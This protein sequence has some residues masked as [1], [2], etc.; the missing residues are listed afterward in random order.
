MTKKEEEKGATLKQA[1]KI[2][3][4]FHDT[5]AEQ[6]QA[7]LESGFLADLR[8][9]NL[10]EVNRW[11]FR[12]LIGLRPYDETMI[13]RLSVIAIPASCQSGTVSECIAKMKEGGQRIYTRKNFEEMFFDKAVG[14]IRKTRL[15]RCDL[16]VIGL[17]SLVI[18]ALGG[19]ARVETSLGELFGLLEA[20]KY[21]RRGALLIDGSSNIFYIRNIRNKLCSVIVDWDDGG[22]N[23]LADYVAS[24]HGYAVGSRVFFR[25]S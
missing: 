10:A 2:L 8:D 20:Q 18:K 24:P 12:R 21:G 9:G 25:E 22:W 5:P 3:S 6:I 4:I 15:L 14:P 16:S 7:I 11:D 17:N 23:F 1:T 13:G 19:E